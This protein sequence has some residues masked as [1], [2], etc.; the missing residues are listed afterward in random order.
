[1]GDE[2]RLGS[3]TDCLGFSFSASRQ[4][5]NRESIG[6]FHVTRNKIRI[7]FHE[8]G[9]ERDVACQPVE[10]GDYKCCL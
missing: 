3:L 6:M 7:G 8:S 9:Q 4:N 5:V 1:M 2:G 10:F